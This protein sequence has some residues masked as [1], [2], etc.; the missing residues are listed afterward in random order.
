MM[1]MEQLFPCTL[2]EI[3]N[4]L[5]SDPI[6][7]MGVDAAEG[8]PLICTR[9]CSFEVVVGKSTIVALV[10]QYFYAVLIGK[11]LKGSL[12]VDSLL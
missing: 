7:E 2:A 11:V 12:G 3:P 1:C 5:L 4:G 9:T 6:L 8:E 10:I